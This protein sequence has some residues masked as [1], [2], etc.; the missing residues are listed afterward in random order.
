MI[1][2]LYDHLSADTTEPMDKISAFVDAQRL[3]YADRDHYFGDPDEIDI[4]LDDLLNPEYIRHRSTERFAPAAIPTPGDPV[5]V[6]HG[7]PTAQQ[8]SPD[9]TEE[10]PGTT[11]LSIIDADGNAVSMT[12]TIEGIFGSQRWAAGFLLNNEMTDFAREVPADGSRP[13]NAV[14]PG[15][16][17]RSSMS[18]S[19][20]FDPEGDLLMVTGSPGGNSIPAYVAKTIVGVLDWGMSAQ[21]AVDHPNIIARG[22][23][24]RVEISVDPGQAIASDLKEKGYNV[25]ERD[26]ENSGLHVI[27]VGPDGLDGAADKRREGVVRT[28]PPANH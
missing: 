15:R 24:V 12:A 14:A 16:R 4:P 26:G 5:M 25:Q 21:E 3:A 18:P 13:A 20:I 27:V 28:V 8:W 1:A 22:E 7:E 17:P 23:K 11:H 10:T 6:L 9:T 19:M 2:A